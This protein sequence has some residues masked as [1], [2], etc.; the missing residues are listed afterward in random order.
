[1]FNRDGNNGAVYLILGCLAFMIFVVVVDN[2]AKMADAAEQMREMDKFW[3]E[4]KDNPKGF[5]FEFQKG[6][7][8]ER[9][10]SEMLLRWRAR[11]EG[12]WLPVNELHGFEDHVYV[13]K[14]RHMEFEKKMF[15][16]YQQKR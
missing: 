11:D 3:E 5:L 14:Q 12:I 1:M 15:E 16:Q 13:N 7:M 2:K 9:Y 4:F 8:P 10:A 6:K